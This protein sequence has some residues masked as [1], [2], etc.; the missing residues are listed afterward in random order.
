M[1]L[2]LKSWSAVL[3]TILWPTLSTK[4]LK[5]EKKKTQEYF[6][7]TN[8]VHLQNIASQHVFISASLLRMLTFSV[9]VWLG[10]FQIDQNGPN[11]NSTSRE[12]LQ[13]ALK[14]TPDFFLYINQLFIQAMPLMNDQFETL[15]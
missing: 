13:K 7:G 6:S 11:F 15:S 8:R 2:Q 3:K 5:Q 10:R 14:A 1:G 4:G 9:R 12:N